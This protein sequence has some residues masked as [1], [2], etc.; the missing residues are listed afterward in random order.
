MRRARWAGAALALT[1]FAAPAGA[2]PAPSVGDVPAGPGR[3]VG[4]VVHPADP[5]RAEAVDVV[6]YAIGAGGQPG[7][8]RTATDAGGAFRF[9]GIATGAEIAYLIG[10]RYGGVPF[11]GPRVSFVP[12]ETERSVTLEVAERTRDGSGLAVVEATFRVDWIGPEL[13]LA[14]S[15][16]LRNPTDRVVYV[17]DEERAARAAPAFRALLPDGVTRFEWPYAVDPEGLVREGREVR[18]FG[19]VYPGEQDIAY[20]YALPA[21]IGRQRLR[22][23]LP[24]GAEQ[25]TLLYPAGGIELA[26]TA[27]APGEPVELGG[28]T[29]RALRGSGLPRGAT[30]ELQLTL[31]EPRRDPTALSIEQVRSFLELD[32]TALQVSEEIQLAVAGDAPLVAPA[33]A[34]LLRIPLPAGASDLSFGGS[35]F[36]GGL[37]FEDGALAVRGPLPPGASSLEL[38][39][40]LPPAE[41]GGAARFE[42]SFDK[43]VPAL[44][45]FVAD[46]GLAVSSDRFHRRR[47]VRTQDAR[48]YLHFE[49]F[50]V[51]PGE[52][53]DLSLAPLG[54]RR[55]APRSVRAAFVFAAALAVG[56]L[57]AAPLRRTRGSAPPG[58]A[59]TDAARS[60]RETLYAAIHDLDHDHETG[61]L[62]DA[63]WREM[64][65][66]LRAR[67]VELLRAEEQQAAPSGAARSEP[68]A[69]EGRA[70]AEGREGSGRA[71]S[72]AARSEPQASEGRAAAPAAAR[73]CDGCGAAAAPG[74][75]FCA[76]CGRP[77]ASDAAA[78]ASG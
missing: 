9:D 50:H 33:D 76:Q 67:A 44:S 75:R 20:L 6:L 38:R 57:L 58:A 72:G 42:R 48:I 5:A 17:T 24:S 61:K 39:Y 15:F 28:R 66:A 34:A 74:A 53:V 25:V 73:A 29:W 22:I 63:D 65:D 54:A 45:V 71:P 21:E 41:V 18:F 52:R 31:P 2:Q 77:L 8:R 19:P 49:A 47:P 1:L 30:L 13:A 23:P 16:R 70:A 11:V 7:V 14:Q 4:R 55:G 32:D 59:A 37:A 27:L 12:G 51:Q 68:Q 3:I 78:G 64:R 69:S 35:G 62:A 10:A 46:S 43:L 36:G 40:R 60:E 26:S 56:L